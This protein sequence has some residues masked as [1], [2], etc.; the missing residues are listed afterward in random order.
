MAKRYVV[1]S[2]F[3]YNG[4]RC[5]VTFGMLGHRCGYVGVPK[6]NRFYGKSYMNIASMID[7]GDCHG[8]LTYSSEEEKSKYPVKSDLWWFGF[9][10]V[11]YGDGKDLDLAIELFPNYREQLTKIKEVEAMFPTDEIVR[12]KKYVEENCKSLADQLA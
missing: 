8:G 11:H 12:N 3:E 1:E 2:D 6:G 10:C 5:V 4:L 9:D 7:Y